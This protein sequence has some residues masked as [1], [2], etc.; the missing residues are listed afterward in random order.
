MKIDGRQIAENIFEDLRKRVGEL[1]KKGVT[2]KLTVILVGDDPASKIYVTQKKL[3]GENINLNVEIK[4]YPTSTT[5]EELLDNIRLLNHDT[6]THGIVVQR[7]LPEQINTDVIQSAIADEKD[8]DGFKYGSPFHVPVVM[9]V[10]MILEEVYR[11][12]VMTGK[13]ENFDKSNYPPE[14]NKENIDSWLKSQ[15]V[16]L[17]GKGSTAGKPLLDYMKEIGVQPVLIDSKT[18]NPKELTKQA[19]IIISSVGKA[20][21]IQPDQLKTGVTLISV[22]LG[23]GDNDKIY[24]D[25]NEEQIKEI[26]SFYTPTPGGVGPI[27]VA[28]LLS[29]LVTAAEQQI[30]L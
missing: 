14:I 1:E 29:N 18:E 7:P 4:P 5:T 21:L 15:R 26:A 25:Y 19:D 17:V 12:I 11:N 20:G 2:P 24:G 13:T 30:Q 22:G 16:V 9:A 28:M 8:I 6:N 23:R 3:K 27:N 10:M